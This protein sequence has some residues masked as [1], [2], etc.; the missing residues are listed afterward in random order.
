MR[1]NAF[2]MVF[3]VR[4]KRRGWDSETRGEKNPS[5]HG[6]PY[7]MHI[8][9]HGLFVQY[10]NWFMENMIF[11]LLVFIFLD[12]FAEPERFR[13]SFGGTYQT[14]VMKTGRLMNSS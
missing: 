10:C 11:S 2:C 12:F 7:K 8:I 14:G 4:W 9:S 13:S 3:H 6:K 5:P 1:E